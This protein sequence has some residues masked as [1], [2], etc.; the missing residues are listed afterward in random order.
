MPSQITKAKLANGTE[1][2]ISTTRLGGEADV[3]GRVPQFTEFT[4]ALEGIAESVVGSLRKIKPRNASVEFG[5]E[6]GLESG[7]L[8]ALLVQGTGTAN[9]KVTLEWGGE[10]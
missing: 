10:E 6:I 3:A 9:L 5:V 7:K 1:I 4:E 2:R 8:T